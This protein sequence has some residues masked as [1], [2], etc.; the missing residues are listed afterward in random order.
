MDNEKFV[1][2][3]TCE[4]VETE[5]GGGWRCWVGGALIVAGVWTLD[6]LAVT[7][8]AIMVGGAC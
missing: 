5:G 6:P 7:V 8:G 1:E 2:L 3:T 4:M